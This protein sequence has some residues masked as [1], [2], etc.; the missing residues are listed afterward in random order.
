MTP[1]TAQHPSRAFL[2]LA[3]AAAFAATAGCVAED[4]GFTASTCVL[5][6]CTPAVAP[7]PT[8]VEASLADGLLLVEQA[9][10]LA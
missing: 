10:A 8:P 4:E 3:F 2:A 9:P 5:G 6:T 7:A 1:V